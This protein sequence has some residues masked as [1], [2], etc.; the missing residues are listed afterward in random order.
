ML[1]EKI[2]ISELD[3]RHLRNWW[4]LAMPPALCNS[5]S[6]VCLILDGGELI[7]GIRSN[8]GAMNVEEIPFRGTGQAALRALK[9]ELV[10]DALLV[11]ERDALSSLAGAID[12]G[13]S[14]RDD[15][16]AQGVV[17][18]Q[19]LRES[20]KIWSEPPLLDLIPPIRASALQRTFDFLVPDNT[21]LVAYVIDES[22]CQVHCSAIAVKES[23]SISLATMHPSIEDMVSERELCRDWR[24]N[25]SI[26]N[27]SVASRL[28][29]PC[30]SIFVEKAAVARILTGPES[31]LAREMKEGNLIVSPAPAWLQGLL[32]G[33]AALAVAS[34]GA[35]RMARFLPKSARAMAGSL[36]GVAQDR[37]KNSSVNPFSMLGFDPLELVGQ[38]RRFYSVS[39]GIAPESS[40]R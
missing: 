17:V 21:A 24:K 22:E 37:I 39:T 28:A 3:G 10:A 36:A 32:G 13:V 33:A 6:Y 12:S 30:I 40:I 1:S 15:Y 19:V 35:K 8:V 4:Q 31:Q 2:E 29:R 11:L 23:G 26:I 14:L 25:Y 16:V 5:I 7:H 20:K 9:R 27:Q 34:E 38:L 18:W